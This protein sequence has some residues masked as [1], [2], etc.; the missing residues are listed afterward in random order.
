MSVFADSLARN[1]GR[2]TVVELVPWAGPLQHQDGERHRET[3]RELSADPRITALTITDNA[4]GHVRLGPLTLGKAI[5]DMG[6]EA[7]VHIACR[8][9][10]RASLES[11]AF[12]LASEG[13]TN[14][15]ALSG[16]YP[17]EGYRGRSRG[18]FDIDSVGLVSLLRDAGERGPSFTI[19]CAINPFKA[20]EAD[21]V[22]QYLKLAMKVRAGAHLAITQ[23]GYDARSWS[24]LLTWNRTQGPGIPLLAGVYVLTRGVARVFHGDQVP[25]IRL[26]DAQLAWAESLAAADDK[27]R[28]AFL[29]FAAKQVAVARGMG[30]AGTYIAGARN[31][32]E[33]D[34][35]LNL[36]VGFEPDWRALLAEV[37]FPEPSAY[38]LF[39]PGDLPQL[40]S[41]R[42][43]KPTK[44]RRVPLAYRFNRLVH[45]AVF[46][47]DSTGFAVGRAFYGRLEA[48]RLG[49]PAHVVEQAVKYPLFHCQDCGDCSLP[50][51]AYQCPEGVCAK[52]QR[53]GPCGGSLNGECE[54][55]GVRCVWTE[56]YDR[57]KPYGEHLMMLE[58]EPVIQD[59]ILR[60]TSA[61]ANTFLGRDHYA[62]SKQGGEP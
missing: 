54:V 5:H 44:A 14:V 45:D 11:V 43:T 27:G 26:S 50:D 21:L 48:A 38:R 42:P 33:V 56:A 32:A 53:N 10:S 28:A 1:D 37:S 35:I 18:V 4:G 12:G 2:T 58:R 30:F 29:E 41:D 31:D 39:E 61:W 47:A 51:I 20:V 9:R 40:S 16:D 3:A 24:E 7:V 19:G 13:L 23:V 59:N 46:D 17:K 49:W 8:D 57:L 6:G 36:A 25:G 52:N 62:R 55:P 22:P 15:L 34:R 60:G